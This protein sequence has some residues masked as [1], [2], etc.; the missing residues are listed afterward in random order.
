MIRARNILRRILLVVLA[1]AVG[2][3]AYLASA[4]GIARNQL[5]MPFGVGLAAVE[6]NSMQPAFS[7]GD[8]LVVSA[9]DADSQSISVGDVVVYQDPTIGLVVHRVVDI[10]GELVTAQGDA[11]NAADTPFDRTLVLA[12]VVA[13]VPAMGALIAGLRSPL[14]LVLLV[15]LALAVVE[16]P[17]RRQQDEDEQKREQLRLQI[18]RLQQADADV[19]RGTSTDG[20][21]AGR[22]DEQERGSENGTAE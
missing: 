10:N 12:R 21:R 17:L 2:L 8:L 15:A 5:P 16:L 11:N 3:A 19:D 6:S 18:A 20:L 4:A 22:K 14:G 1:A 13:V 7:R 9:V